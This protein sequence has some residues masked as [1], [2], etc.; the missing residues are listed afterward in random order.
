MF[1]EF[2]ELRLVK[3]AVHP[4]IRRAA[5]E[6]QASSTANLHLFQVEWAAAFPTSSA[7]GRVQ[8]SACSLHG[9]WN[10]SL[11]R[12]LGIR[13]WLPSTITVCGVQDTLEEA[14]QH[15]LGE[16]GDGSLAIYLTLITL[17]RE[18]CPAA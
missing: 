17:R 14:P 5:R 2:Q 18:A 10:N 13:C 7:V 12:L 4:N 1:K 9:T 3:A 8:T 16:K 6:M 15:K 11:R